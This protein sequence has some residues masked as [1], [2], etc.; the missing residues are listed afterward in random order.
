MFRLCTGQMEESLIWAKRLLSRAE[1]VDSDE[2]RL[3]GDWTACDS[4]FFLGALSKSVEHANW[5]LARYD[6]QRHK[7]V[8]DL[9]NHDPKTIALM[10]RAGAEWMLGF[11]E[12]AAATAE[13]AIAHADKRKHPFDQC[14]V[15]HFGVLTVYGPR[16]DLDRAATLIAEMENQAAEQRLL[17]MRD[18]LAPMKRAL[19]LASGKQYADA[20][21]SL[22]AAL[23]QWKAA[24][25]A[26]V[27]PYLHAVL[28]ECA[29]GCGRRSEAIALLDEAL[30]QIERPGWGERYALAEVLRV[31]ALA[32]QSS[33]EIEE[34]KALFQRAL[35][36]AR[37][38]HAKAW[39]LRAA[40]GLAR[41]LRGQGK[42]DQ[43]RHIL[44]PVFLW[45][46]EGRDTKD[47]REASSL[48]SELCTESS[49]PFVP[50]NVIQS[51]S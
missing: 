42:R 14:W 40:I 30:T 43:A 21:N 5:L 7:H 10:Y 25:L 22:Q 1:T 44:E 2:M 3:V 13:M 8:A 38:Q 6:D 47:L 39:E 23:E 28:A 46:T 16:G 12:R 41:L 35:E 31:K 33:G 29:L 24:G 45:F 48:L 27:V 18:V 50:L 19:C 37:Q 49:M 34:S 51:D 20:F 32:L 11:P 4:Y 26:I 17:F 15:R 36:V 9:V